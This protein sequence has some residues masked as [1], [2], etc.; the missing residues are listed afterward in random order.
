MAHQVQRIEDL[1]GGLRAKPLPASR[2]RGKIRH[3]AGKSRVAPRAARARQAIGRLGSPQGQRASAAAAYMV[4]TP[5]QTA[6][7][8]VTVARIEGAG[9]KALRAIEETTSVATIGKEAE[10]RSDPQGDL[11]QAAE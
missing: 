11:G 6:L 5:M 10:K 1:V 3:A 4:S 9:A 7:L 2:G 8:R